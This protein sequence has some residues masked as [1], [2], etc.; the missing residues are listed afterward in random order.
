[1]TSVRRYA[2]QND[3]KLDSEVSS[4]RKP[5][6]PHIF[7]EKTLR[8]IQ[9]HSELEKS[10]CVCKVQEVQDGIYLHSKGTSVSQGVHGLP[11]LVG[12][13]PAC[14]EPSRIKK[15]PKICGKRIREDAVLPVQCAPLWPC[16]GASYILTKVLALA[17]LMVRT[18]GVQIIPYLDDFLIFGDSEEEVAQHLNLMINL[19]Q[20]SGWLIN[21]EKSQ[22]QPAQK[23]TLLGYTID[24]I[25][26]KI[27]FTG[28][29]TNS[30]FS[31]IGSGMLNPP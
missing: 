2:A 15:I 4:R 28:E 27:F 21:L 6:L 3:K 31:H 26:N 30:N 23:L 18:E 25:V 19:L 16:L 17:L 14:L 29:N 12:R 10:E 8:K 9:I 24:S 5:L 7:E 11:C 22:I 13:L 20:K 1:M